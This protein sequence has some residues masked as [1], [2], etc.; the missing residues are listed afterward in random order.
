MLDASRTG[1][2][3]VDHQPLLARGLASLLR[4]EIGIPV[5][6][7]SGRQELLAA[8]MADYQ[9]RLVV[10]GTTS[11]RQVSLEIVTLIT[12]AD[13]D[14]RVIVLVDPFGSI[15]PNELVRLKVSSLV[16]RFASLDEVVLAIRQVL[17]GQQSLD[18]YMAARLLNEL[19]LAIRRADAKSDG[20]LT[21][22]EMQVLELVAD[23]LPN[24]E[25]ANG[26]HISENTVKNHMRSVHEKLG[27]KTRT[28][29]VVKAARDG[30]LG[31]R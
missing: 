20:G 11:G 22:R 21:K 26:L 23:G 8:E 31:L 16:S 15:E 6:Q 25:V 5:Y 30:L 14:C 13:P 1:V 9:P 18:G 2:L 10:I 19:T 28:E 3:V 24:R 17:A 29:A 12:N 7:A 27:V 4:D